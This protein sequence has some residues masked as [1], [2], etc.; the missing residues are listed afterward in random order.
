MAEEVREDAGVFVSEC[1]NVKLLQLNGQKAYVVMCDMSQ[2]VAQEGIQVGLFQEPYVFAKRVC[3]MPAGV[4]QFISVSGKAA[5]CVF[6][7]EIESMAVEECKFEDGVCVWIK[8][9]VAELYVVSL[10][11]KPSGNVYECVEYM[12]RVLKVVNGKSVVV[13]MDANACSDLWF[14]K[15]RGR[16]GEKERRGE[17]FAEWIEA[18]RMNV[19]NEP[20][21][22]FTFSGPRGESDIDVTLYRGARRVLEW[23]LMDEWGISDHNPILIQ[24]GK[25]ETGMNEDR[26]NEVNL[27][28]VK[29]WTARRCDWNVYRGLVSSL[30]QSY[31]YENYQGLGAA[32]K[33]RLMYDWIYK[34]NDECMRRVKAGTKKRGVVWWT[35]EL[36]M[37]KKKVRR[38]RKKYQ[39]ERK[40]TGDTGG[41]RWN[42]WRECVNVYRIKIR[43]AKEKDWREYVER[44]NE[45]DPWGGLYRMLMGKNERTC[46]TGLKVG[47]R[48]TRDWKDSACVLLSEFFPPDDGQLIEVARGLEVNEGV[49]EFDVGEVASAVWKM[50]MGK[51][52]GM[53]G[54][55]NEM[56]KRVYESVPEFIK[57]MY[58]SCLK[59]GLF[60]KKWKEARVV[61]LLKS[62]EKDRTEPRSYRPISLLSGLG[63]VLERMMTER[64]I[65]KMNGKWNECQFGFR[66]NKCTEDAWIRMKEL[67]RMND[68]KH[69]AGVFVDFKGAFDNLLWRVCLRKL[70][71]IGSTGEEMDLWYDY[72]NERK[73]C[74][75]SSVDEVWKEVKRGCPQGSIGGPNL[76]NLC[77]NELLDDLER[78]NVSVVAYADDVVLVIG[79]RTRNELEER[80]G[81]RMK[82]VYDWGM[83]AGVEVSE[84]KTVCMILKGGMNM[85]NR[86]VKIDVNRNVKSLKFVEKV[87]YLGVWMGVN[88]DYKVHVK[89]MRA[90]VNG[91][92]GKFRRVLRKDWGMKKGVLSVIVKG[93]VEPAIMYASSV[94]YEL[95]ELKCMREELNRCQRIVLYACTRVCRTVS[96][97]AMQVIA[98]SLPWDLECMRRADLYKL[99]KGLPMNERDFVNDEEMEE[100]NMYERKELVSE[101]VNAVWQQRWDVSVKGRVTYEWVRKVRFS[102][103][104]K[105]FDPDLETC[106]FLTGHGSFN[107]FLY[108]RGLN[109]SRACVCGNEREDWVHVL[110]K[111]KQYADVR[112]LNRM[113]IKRKNGVWDVSE[114]VSDKDAYMRLRKYAKSVFRKRRELIGRINE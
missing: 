100:M 13:C 95:M 78:E 109:H 4:K 62:S 1:M 16:S 30:A 77:M 105:G 90:R 23:K 70:H 42:E 56:I 66:R 10:Y 19:L 34:A 64:M 32:E 112:D 63:K 47:N 36:N 96:T 91:I 103:R 40:K 110:C 73:V 14:S 50:S 9:R 102:C 17:V 75:V 93:M 37:L 45:D 43:E 27:N 113:K 8:N 76:W 15:A 65:R 92:M 87:K 83:N 21:G 107:S 97:E 81:E 82:M 111:C 98:G 6:D 33:V 25:S 51:A 3:G 54:V 106:Y 74:M 18:R 99:R 72:F 46:L 108:E 39:D 44:A 29:R 58:D 35:N 84:G 104:E 86:R 89:G 5:V 22:A 48:W 61:V 53:D 20:S 12:D 60:P 28:R 57:S 52:P 11:A 80:I 67:V 85:L 94:W 49:A 69:V 38:L 41:E 7:R 114:C 68:N 31:G 26:V 59:E 101:R 71:E 79:A 55:T 2:Y 88:M 24:V